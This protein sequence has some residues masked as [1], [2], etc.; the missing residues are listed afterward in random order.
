VVH[1]INDLQLIDDMMLSIRPFA[2]P[3]GIL[4]SLISPS[5]TSVLRGIP[6]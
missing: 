6:S 1:I 4:L 2:D 3:D 5:S